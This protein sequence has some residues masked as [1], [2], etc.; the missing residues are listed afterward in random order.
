MKLSNI[1]QNPL[2]RKIDRA[3]VAEIKRAIK[4][5]GVIKPLVYTEVMTEKGKENMLTDGHHRYVAL[6]EMGYKDAPVV[7]SDERGIDTAQFQDMKTV[8]KAITVLRSLSKHLHGQINKAKKP[9]REGYYKDKDGN[10]RRRGQRYGGGALIYGLRRH[11]DKPHNGNGTE[12]GSTPPSNGTTQKHLQG[13]HDQRTHS[14][15]GRSAI[16]R[17][18]ERKP[19]TRQEATR[20]GAIKGGAVHIGTIAIPLAVLIP[21]LFIA[22]SLVRKLPASSTKP[23]SS[24]LRY[25]YPLFSSASTITSA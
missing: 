19:K 3:K 24:S 7:M 1:L 20:R 22:S 13:Q 15:T 16:A 25:S 2:N 14:P 17:E 10:C 5:S 6:K 18:W 4:T 11:H 9:C 23:R 21:V 12:N 8:K